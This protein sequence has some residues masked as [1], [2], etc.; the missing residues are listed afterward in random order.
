M[1]VDRQLLERDALGVRL[2]GELAEPPLL[3]TGRRRT[4]LHRLLDEV[5]GIGV[6]HVAHF[7]IA[8]LPLGL[9]AVAALTRH[10][11]HLGLEAFDVLRGDMQHHQI[12]VREVPV[13]VGVRLHTAAG[14]G[15]RGLVPVAR[16]LQDL[17]AVVQNGG[18]TAN[19]ILDRTFDAAERVHVLRFG[20]GAE[21]I[22]GERRSETFTSARILPC[23]MR[24]C[25][26]LSARTMS[27]MARM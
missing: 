1:G 15:L 3:G 24:A 25:E 14:G 8:E 21:W 16:F 13:I 5:E 9:E 6:D 26:M 23:S 27:R 12:R 7:H 20:T 11:R 10:F 2:A 22:V 18:L 4:E 17:A 19:L